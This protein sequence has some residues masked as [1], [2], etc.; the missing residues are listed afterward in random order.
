MKSELFKEIVC[1]IIILATDG[2]FYTCTIF[3][4]YLATYYKQYDETISMRDVF[5]GFGTCLIGKLI[6]NFFLPYVI[7]FLG[8]KKTL[9]L[10]AILYFINF[11]IFAEYPS[12]LTLYFNPIFQGI[13]FQF[14]ILPINFFMSK[15]YENGIMYSDHIYSGFSISAFIWSLCLAFIINP[16]NKEMDKVTYINGYEEKYFNKTISDRMEIFLLF[17]GI[18]SLF[19]IMICTYLIKDPIN[20]FPSYKY[21]LKR[22]FGNLTEEEKNDYNSSLVKLKEEISNSSIDLNK[23]LLKD[24]LNLLENKNEKNQNMNIFREKANKEMKNPKFI[25]L[26]LIFLLKSASCSYFYNY[27][28]YISYSIVNNDRLISVLFAFVSIPDIAARYILTFIWNKHG[29]YRTMIISTCLSIFLDLIFLFIGYRN[30]YVFIF[31][32]FAQVFNFALGYLLGN[33]TLFSLYKPEIALFLSKAFES[34]MLFR[35]YYTISLNYFFVYGNNYF[36]I[37]FIMLIG[38]FIALY[39]FIINF[40]KK[41]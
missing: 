3:Y 27:S 29:F 20:L 17:N 19:F 5:T 30:S 21:Y 39:L 8:C 33:M 13:I 18:I 10:G 40:K 2:V 16:Q 11:Y 31:L 22:F 4:P 25:L 34:Y 37:F 36:Y 6:G 35:K 38:E 1:F 12:R 7:I 26:I 28:K 14:K 9:Q 23:S 24:N 41:N 15:K 32:I